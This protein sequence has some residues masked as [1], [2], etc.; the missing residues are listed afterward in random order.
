M[1]FLC[2]MGLVF[3]AQS[4]IDRDLSL[5]GLGWLPRGVPAVP[6]PHTWIANVGQH[7][8]L[9][10]CG[11]WGYNSDPRAFKASTSLPSDIFVVPELESSITVPEG[12]D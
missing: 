6:L 4:L 10:K 5:I 12:E 7:T 2:I 9:C 11:F 3:E 1:L 8:Q